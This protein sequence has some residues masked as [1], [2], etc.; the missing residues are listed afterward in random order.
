LGD[1]FVLVEGIEKLKPNFVFPELTENE[2]NW[3]FGLSIDSEKSSIQNWTIWIEMRFS[4]VWKCLS[5]NQI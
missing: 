3:K 1:L 2:F 4:F 5:W